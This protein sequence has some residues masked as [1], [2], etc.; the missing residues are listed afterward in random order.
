MFTGHEHR[1]HALEMLL[2]AMRTRDPDLHARYER[3][4]A[5]WLAVAE[6]RERLQAGAPPPAF[7]PRAPAEGWKP[8]ETAP[9]QPE[10]RVTATAWGPRIWLRDG[11]QAARGRWRLDGPVDDRLAD[12]RLADDRPA[13]GQALRH[14]QWEDLDREPLAFT[15]TEWRELDD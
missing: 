4:S 10:V 9:R 8:I 7:A 11:E 2:L 14:A 15:P 1:L 5:L 13:D 12:D 3:L 6:R